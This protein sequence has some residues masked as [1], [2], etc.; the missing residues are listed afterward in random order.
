MHVIRSLILIVPLLLGVAF[1]TLA[2]RKLLGVL[3]RRRG[4]NIVGLWGVFQPFAD[5]LKFILTR[6]TIPSFAYGGVF[7]FVSV[8]SLAVAFLPWA[9]IPFPSVYCDLNLGIL[10]VLAASSISVYSVMVSGWVSNSKYSI[11][12]AVRAAAQMISYEVAIGLIILCACIPANSFNLSCLIAG[13]EGIWYVIPLFPMF[14]LFCVSAL[15]ETHRVPFDLTEGESELVSGYHVEYGGALFTLFFLAEYL[16][17]LFM[18]G[19]ISLLFFGG[20]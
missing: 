11:D 17:L 16:H 7:L 5:G 20:G 4:P 12:A 18:A 2:E 8:F 15:A 13:Q 3:Q 14:V 1:I 6:T 19:F 10:F 9:V